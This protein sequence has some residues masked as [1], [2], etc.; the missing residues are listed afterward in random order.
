VSANSVENAGVRDA[1]GRPIMK[2]SAREA[3]VPAEGWNLA[4]PPTKAFGG[5]SEF[6]YRTAKSG[7]RDSLAQP[8][9]VDYRLQLFRRRP[10]EQ[11]R[12]PIGASAGS[13][14]ARHRP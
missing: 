9:A 4:D 6:S 13:A 8:V 11:N 5:P 14:H 1:Q 3:G 7:T 2:A 12:S 10:F